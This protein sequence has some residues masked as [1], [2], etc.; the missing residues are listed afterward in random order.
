[1]RNFKLADHKLYGWCDNCNKETVHLWTE[2]IPPL[3]GEDQGQ[4]HFTCT[5]CD[6]EESS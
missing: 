2:T 1:M 4:G 5:E 3:H 6:T